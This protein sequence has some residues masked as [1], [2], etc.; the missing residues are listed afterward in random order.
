M[1]TD[2]VISRIK[3]IVGEDAFSINEPMSKHTTFRIG[4]PARF[5]CEP[6]TESQLEELIKLF[7]NED[8]PYT[9]IGNGSNLLVSDKGYEGVII[10]LLDKFSEIKGVRLSQE[11][12][13]M[14]PDPNASVFI[15]VEAGARNWHVGSYLLEKEVSGF[16]FAT[17][18]PGTIGGAVMMNA[19]AYGGEMKDIVCYA[20]VLDRDGKL[21]KLSNKELE[22]SYR[23][24]AIYTKDLIVVKVVLGLPKGNPTEIKGI[25][26][27]LAKRRRTKQ[28]LE[29]PSGGSTFKRPK[30]HYAS[31][32][33][34]EAGLRGFTVGGAQV[35]EKHAGFV[36]NKG[37]ATAEDVVNLVNRVSEIVFEKS[38]V[39]LE[40]EVR[41][42]GF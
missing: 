2:I 36:I 22:F 5:F 16:E 10:R 24:S 32:L 42:L 20:E 37:G 35:S 4:G 18:I 31:Q 19:G 1:L 9:V 7:A 30:G 14:A 25:M 15:E 28:P 33:I 23:K 39:H 3:K 8:I 21:H 17:G 40:M 41:K 34:D 26:D 13:D 12:K 38:G 29:F 6:Q 27:D 11:E